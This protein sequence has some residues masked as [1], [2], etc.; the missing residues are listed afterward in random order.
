MQL[1]RFLVRTEYWAPEDEKFAP[2]SAKSV[3]GLRKHCDGI[4]DA[5][6]T[7]WTLL[8]YP[9]ELLFLN[10]C[11]VSS[12]KHRE[13]TYWQEKTR[14]PSSACMYVCMY[15]IIIITVDVKVILFPR[16]SY[17]TAYAIVQLKFHILRK[18]R[19]HNDYRIHKSPPLMQSI[20][21]EPISLRSILILFFHLCLYLPSGVLSYLLV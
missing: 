15:V 14:T 16:A 21:P 7:E 11:I 13:R 18:K 4:Y 1:A 9:C 19:H 5:V 17:S 6:N 12:L 3:L 10:Y 20:P 8:N 2:Y